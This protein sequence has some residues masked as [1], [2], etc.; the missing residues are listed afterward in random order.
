QEESP[1]GGD[2]TDGGEVIAGQGDPQD[3]RLPPWRPGAHRHRQQIKAGFIYPDNGG[4]V[5]LGFF[6][7][8]GQRCSDHCLIAS[9]LRWVARSMGCCRLQ[10][11][12]RSSRPT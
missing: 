7:M 6:L 3:W 5:L 11:A 2:P 9:S 1:I 10:P 4:V 12:S 8:A